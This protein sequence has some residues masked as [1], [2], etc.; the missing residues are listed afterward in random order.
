MPQVAFTK[1]SKGAQGRIGRREIRVVVAGIPRR[2]AKESVLPLPKPRVTQSTNERDRS[3]IHRNSMRIASRR[4][5]LSLGGEEG[6]D[7]E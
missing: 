4:E 2:R 1:L 7:D 6:Q 3:T 5:I